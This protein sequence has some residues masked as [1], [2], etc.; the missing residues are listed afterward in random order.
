MI[1]PTGI[2]SMVALAV[3]TSGTGTPIQGCSP[4]PQPS[5]TGADIAIVAAVAG[6]VVGTI[7]VVEVRKENHIV[8]GCVVANQSGLQLRDEIDKKTY[9]LI[10]A[11]AGTKAGDI[12]Q[13]RGTK[14]KAAKGSTSDP[15]F[16]VERVNRTYGPCGVDAAPSDGTNDPAQTPKAR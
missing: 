5:H 4:A 8:K 1:R 3:F 10:G 12:V 2:A 7:A 13:L 14:E 11:S 9:T 6:V 15:S 16:V